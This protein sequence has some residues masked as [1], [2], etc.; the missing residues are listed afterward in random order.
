MR[1]EH[2]EVLLKPDGQPWVLGQGVM[3][4]TYKA[5]DRNLRCEVALKV[6]NHRFLADPGTREGFLSE[7]R[8]AASIRHANIANVFHMGEEKG[9]V[10]YAMEFIEGRTLDQCILDDGPLDP[11]LAT[12]VA[13]EVSRALGVIHLEG[14]VHRDIRPA[15]I[16]LRCDDG[17][18]SLVKLIDFGLA[19]A[20]SKEAVAGLAGDG[21]LQA[22]LAVPHYASP[23]QINGEPVDIRSDI[24][25]LGATLYEML[26]GKAPFNGSFA[27]ILSCHL[28]DNPPMEAL[29]S[30]PSG[31]TNAVAKMLGKCP[32]DRFQ[33]PQDVRAAL[34]AVMATMDSRVL[35]ASSTPER[36]VTVSILEILKHRRALPPVEAMVLLQQVARAM[37]GVA[38]T[39]TPPQWLNL[40]LLHVS[41][42]SAATENLSTISTLHVFVRAA[43][44]EIHP[45]ETVS[46]PSAWPTGALPCASHLAALLMYDL[47]GGIRAGPRSRFAPIPALSAEGNAVLREAMET[48]HAGASAQD[49]LESLAATITRAPARPAIQSA[50]SSFVT[51][52]K[53]FRSGTA[54]PVPRQPPPRFRPSHQL[55]AGILGLTLLVTV[56]VMVFTPSRDKAPRE[57]TKSGDSPG[58]PDAELTISKPRASP[59][60]A[61]TFLA[62]AETAKMRDDDAGALENFSSAMDH[63]ADPEYARKQ[64]EMIAARMASDTGSLNAEKFGVM[65]YAL[66]R[67]A[68]HD[69]VSAKVL[70]GRRLR[71]S[72]PQLALKWL[73]SAA[74]QGNT[75]A[76]TK[77][78]L[79]ISNGRGRSEPDL[80]RAAAWLQQGAANGDPEAMVALADCKLYGT[81]LPK[82]PIGAVELLRAATAIDPIP[83]AMVILGDVLARGIPGQLPPN[84][85]EARELFES[86]RKMGNLDAQAN[87]AVLL[88][89]GKGASA[90]PAKALALWKEGAERKNAMCMWYYARSLE[91]GISGPPQPG[92]ARLWYAAAAR[93]NNPAAID[94]CRK[95][96][97]NPT[98]TGAP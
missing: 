84:P 4:V 47:L 38:A 10:F 98:T 48:P 24:Y 92:Q 65:R 16:M 78:G 94:W 27:E 87:L 26:A 71:E 45:H 6:I 93:A 11:L 73:T 70:L 34:M 3:G 29:A 69:V 81:G 2:F 57:N 91:A 18:D 15:N 42:A 83:E 28:H 9:S 40:A 54:N 52:H 63:G 67:A 68:G 36:E 31:L 49:F 59:D 72:E 96:G 74:A 50:Q 17:G 23:E 8:A 60:P 56:A 22:A 33:T 20:V 32:A 43:P 61:A 7:A 46:P 19:K 12:R 21:T 89:N 64:M 79:M 82:D 85:A 80:A 14:M 39:D 44:R 76:M 88:Y 13:V 97:I 66:E 55:A 30:A 25:S 62:L 58:R 90:D 41:P 5:F 53:A 86:A 95:Q 75:E 37:E 77:A 35:N 1:F 51:R